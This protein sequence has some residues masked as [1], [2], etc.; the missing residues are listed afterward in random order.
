MGTLLK[1]TPYVLFLSEYHFG[2]IGWL[3][4]ERPYLLMGY[5]KGS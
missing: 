3:L 2:D 4:M 5:L 1:G